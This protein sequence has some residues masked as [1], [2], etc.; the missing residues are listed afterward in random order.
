MKTFIDLA[1]SEV[2]AVVQ[3]NFLRYKEA[4]CEAGF[5]S[6]AKAPELVK[7]SLAADYEFPKTRYLSPSLSLSLSLSFFL[8]LS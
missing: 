7:R 5:E 4:V 6:V 2:F 1:N 3:H 8:S